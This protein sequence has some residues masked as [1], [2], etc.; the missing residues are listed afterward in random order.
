MI[1]RL[2]LGTFALIGIITGA[3]PA[4][5]ANRNFGINGFD[6]VRVDGPFKVRLTTGVAP[7]ATASG[8][9]AALDR[10]AIDVQGRTLVV[11]A[12][13]SGWGG[14]P[15]ENTGPVEINLGTHEL[16][17]AWLNGAGSLHVDKVKA[18]S[19]DLSVHGSG[20]VAIGRADVDQLRASVSG[21]GT[22]IVGGRAG[23][24]TAIV[25]GISTLDASGL[26]TKD[27]TIGAEGPAT[28]R[29]NVS[30][31]AKIDGSGVA[32]IALTGGPACTAK[33]NGS[34]SVSGCR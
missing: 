31:A 10:V 23:K 8:S 32:T 1:V 20:A 6:R 29:A 27:A 34:A 4:D 25:R 12:S 21:T 3:A 16:S 2:V 33:L 17:A 11:H 5:A 15:G 22:A 26:A 9:S 30:N 28:V 18:L 19:F 13:R 24:L 7:F 14:Y